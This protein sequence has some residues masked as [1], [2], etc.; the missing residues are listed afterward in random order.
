MGTVL[1]LPALVKCAKDA[2]RAVK[3]KTIQIVHAV[4]EATVTHLLNLPHFEVRGYAVEEN[5]EKDI[6]HLYCKLTVE[7]AIC[8][9][10]KGV[11]SGIK[12]HKERCVRDLDIWNKRT[13]IHFQIRRFECEE[14]GHRFTEE[15]QA[16]GWRRHQ[17]M[18]FEQAVYQQCLRSSK[19]A[20][21][22]EFHLSQCTVRIIFKRWA[23]RMQNPLCL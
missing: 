23:Q 3:S 1:K 16:I 22:E 21:A 17:T 4:Q 19:K 2:A 10:C 9:L 11:C 15:L 12:E 8:P 13:F 14:C 5:G 6:L 20:V 7:V 18:R